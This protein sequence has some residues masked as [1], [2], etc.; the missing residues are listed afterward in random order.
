MVSLWCASFLSEGNECLVGCGHVCVL[1]CWN[2]EAGEREGRGEVYVRPVE[3]LIPARNAETARKSSVIHFPF[4]LQVP[5]HDLGMMG[6]RTEYSIK[7]I[8]GQA[9]KLEG[10]R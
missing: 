9:S 8:V 4:S 5:P 10:R 6:R 7:R 1:Y 3:R 2:G